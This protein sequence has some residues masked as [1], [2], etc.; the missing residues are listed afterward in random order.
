MKC[1]ER[2]ENGNQDDLVSETT[3]LL[4]SNAL[5]LKLPPPQ[6]INMKEMIA[7]HIYLLLR[8]FQF[9]TSIL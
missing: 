8:F 5:W 4:C 1:T 2:K 9:V 3:Y 6:I 7:G